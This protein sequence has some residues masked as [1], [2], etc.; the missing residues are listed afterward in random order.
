MSYSC[1]VPVVILNGGSINSSLDTLVKTTKGVSSSVEASRSAMCQEIQDLQSS[2]CDHENFRTEA[3][4]LKV[5]NAILE[6]QLS[7][8]RT[9]ISSLEAQI[10]KLQDMQ[11]HLRSRADKLEYDLIEHREKHA[12]ITVDNSN[13][14]QKLASLQQSL[15]IAECE[16]RASHREQEKLANLKQSLEQELEKEKVERLLLMIDHG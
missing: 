3:D 10:E 9:S 16:L 8:A 13:H 5:C 7:T 11:E 4:Q 6:T 14:E 12:K 2:L 15:I 1:D